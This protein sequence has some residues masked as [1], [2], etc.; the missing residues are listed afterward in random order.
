MYY[1]TFFAA[2]AVCHHEEYWQVEA[3]V[4]VWLLL[5]VEEYMFER[6]VLNESDIV[7]SS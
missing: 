3:N 1:D 6:L 5:S 2:F 4:F 7:I